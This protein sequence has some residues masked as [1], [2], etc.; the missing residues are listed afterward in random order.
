MRILAKAAQLQTIMTTNLGTMLL[1]HLHQQ[2]HQH[3]GPI[4]YGGVITIAIGIDLGG[5][6]QL[7]GEWYVALPTPRAVVMITTSKG[8]PYIRESTTTL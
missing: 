6:A 2:A 5:L 8:R 4:T 1:F 7:T 3:H